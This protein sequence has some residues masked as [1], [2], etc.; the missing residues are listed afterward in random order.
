MKYK[1][2]DRDNPN[3]FMDFITDLVRDSKGNTQKHTWNLKR[4]LG[5]R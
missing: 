4:Y 3:G 1:E 2:Y 5:S